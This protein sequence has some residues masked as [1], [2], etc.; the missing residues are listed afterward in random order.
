[1]DIS[2]K[3]GMS[4]LST[5]EYLYPQKMNLIFGTIQLLVLLTTVFISTFKPWKST[6]AKKKTI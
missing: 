4:S 5:P 1:M 3:L 6:K 2:G